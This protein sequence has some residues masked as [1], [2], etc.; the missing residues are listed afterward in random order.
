MPAWPLYD[1]QKEEILDI[2]LEGKPISKADPR[3]ARFNVV[4]KHSSSDI[5]CNHVVSRT[6]NNNLYIDNIAILWN[7]ITLTAIVRGNDAVTEFTVTEV[8]KKGGNDW[9]LL[10]LTFTS[11]RDTHQIAH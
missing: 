6:P 5:V 8:Y 2:D 10:A 7:R 4:E 1:T 11:V 3:K 9:K